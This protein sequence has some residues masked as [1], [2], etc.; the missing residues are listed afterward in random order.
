MKTKEV[1]R[2][3]QEADPSGELEVSVGN[4]DIFY[5]DVLP[6]Y[7]DGRQQVLTRD[8]SCPYYNVVGA[9]YRSSGEKVVIHTLS[10]DSAVWED[11]EL[12]IDYSDLSEQSR[13]AYKKA[14][15]KARQDALECK[16]RI[17]WEY[18]L[19]HVKGRAGELSGDQDGLEEKAKEFFD[20]HLSHKDSIP[21]DIPI[22][23]ESYCSRRDKQWGREVSVRYD[24]T[25][26]WV[27]SLNRN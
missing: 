10:I 18:F 25:E 24:L 14:D 11:P 1:I 19:K 21:A 9:R 17:E 16:N 5:I 20:K 22:V 23:G 13:E 3:L 27:L 26:G 15:D 12:P 2:R 8:E 7:Y 6:A 4:L